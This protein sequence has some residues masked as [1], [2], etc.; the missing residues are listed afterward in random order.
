MN[1]FAHRAP[2]ALSLVL[3]ASALAGCNAGTVSPGI[4]ASLTDFTR[5]LANES[6]VKIWAAEE[7]SNKVFGLSSDAKRVLDVISTKKQPV[8]GGNPLTLKVDHDRNLFVTD[9]SGGNAGVIQE[10]K[11]GKFTRAYAPGC[12]VSN[13]S[14]FTGVLS[15]SAAD[16]NNVF[17]IMKQIQYKVGTYTTGGSGYEYWPNGNP[18][19]TLVEVLLP[20]DCSGICFYDAGDVDSSGNLWLRDYGAAVTESRR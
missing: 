17:A 13:C 15:D 3:V 1:A 20:S 12:A 9:V 4:P 19:A 7:S 5:P 11:D 10:Y 16:K 6:G 8:K 2:V 14:S 18:S